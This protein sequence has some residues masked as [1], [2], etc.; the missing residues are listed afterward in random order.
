MSF[1]GDLIG[2]FAKA[3]ADAAGDIA[4]ENEREREYQMRADLEEKKAKAA[5]IRQN[6]LAILRAQ[7]ME[8]NRIKLEEDRAAATRKRLSDQ[9]ADIDAARPTATAERELSQAQSRAPSVDSNVMEILKSKLSPAELKKVYGVDTGQVAALDD[10]LAIAR[11]KGYYDAEEHL[12][13]ARKEAIAATEAEWKRQMDAAK[14]ERDERAVAAREKVA[15]AALVRAEK[16]GS[17]SANATERNAVARLNSERTALN[18]EL[19]NLAAQVQAGVLKPAEAA[20]LR[21]EL[22]KQLEDVKRRLRE[23]EKG[24]APAP[25]TGGKFKF[26]GKG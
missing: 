13:S 2:S 11:K 16:V 21:T 4:K 15:D 17:G 5:E 9:F 26:L 7:E 25:S 14:G 8:K 23:E 10:S 20:P 19:A 6:N 22:S 24:G 3:G 12:K 18:Q 1:I